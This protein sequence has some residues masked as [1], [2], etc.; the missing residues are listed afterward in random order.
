LG[1]QDIAVASV[2]LRRTSPRLLR[3]VRREL[4]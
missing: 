1:A 4:F 3:E 2:Q